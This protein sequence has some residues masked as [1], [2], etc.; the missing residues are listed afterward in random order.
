MWGYGMVGGGRVVCL[1]GGVV[2]WWVVGEWGSGR[3]G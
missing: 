3:V 2:E 1:V